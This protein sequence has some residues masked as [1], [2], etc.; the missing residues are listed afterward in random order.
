MAIFAAMVVPA[1]MLKTSQDEKVWWERC[2][3]SFEK[4][5]PGGMGRR[6]LEN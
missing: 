1:A 4:N 3:R 5:L 2:R 6:E